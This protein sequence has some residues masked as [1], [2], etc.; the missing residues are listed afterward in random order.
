MT[1]TIG[2]MDKMTDMDKMYFYPYPVHVVNTEG[3]GLRHVLQ[4]ATRGLM[5]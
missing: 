1:E 2:H 5:I 3:R 4:P